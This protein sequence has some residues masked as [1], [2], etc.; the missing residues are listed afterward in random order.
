MTNYFLV[1][2]KL[3]REKQEAKELKKKKKMNS[4]LNKKSRIKQPKS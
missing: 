3:M 2:A 4:R 1:Q